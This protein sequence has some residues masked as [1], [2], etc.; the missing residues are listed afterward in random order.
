MQHHVC[1]LL[2]DV[3][4]FLKSYFFIF[5]LM[6]G[7]LETYQHIEQSKPRTNSNPQIKQLV[8]V[9]FYVI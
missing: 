7:W 6:K 3:S 9:I 8:I 1:M 2:Q 4:L 5:K